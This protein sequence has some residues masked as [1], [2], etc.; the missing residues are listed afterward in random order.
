MA[1]HLPHGSTRNG[2]AISHTHAPSQVQPAASIA[3][4][5]LFRRYLRA[6]V[7]QAHTRGC[8]CGELDH[9]RPSV[10]YQRAT[11]SIIPQLEYCAVLMMLIDHPELAP[12]S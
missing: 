10:K 6:D 9:R 7:A 1:S 5:M 12:E 8:V 3:L 2:D 11:P 4:Q